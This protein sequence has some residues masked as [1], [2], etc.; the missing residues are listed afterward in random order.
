[1][2]NLYTSRRRKNPARFIIL[3]LLL[4]AVIF[5]F[6]NKFIK[7]VSQNS[8]SL[9]N[10]AISSENLKPESLQKSAPNTL[11]AAVENALSGTQGTY[12]VFIKN[13]KTNETYQINGHKVF[14]AGSLYKLWIMGEAMNQIESGDLDENEQLSEDIGV[15]NQKFRISDDLAELTDGTIDLT[16]ASAL[17]QMITISH[18][19]AALLLT[20]KLKLS[21]VAGYLKKNDLNESIV[22]TNGESPTT[23][24]ADIGLF[25]EK[26]YKVQLANPEYT[27]KMIDLLKKQTINDK[28]PIG[29]PEGISIAHKTGEIEYFT[30]DAGIV[31]SNSGDYIIAVL[32]QSDYPPGAEERISMISKAVYDYFEK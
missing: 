2:R 13:L 1:M 30:H 23:T 27:Q 29:L 32:S 17:N 28:L 9:N 4:S 3:I 5:L 19:Y 20:E 22:G 15:L 18:N 21:S 25:F 10:P 12:G 16:V 31:F 6:Y 14:E 7:S 8:K 24:P 26:L 11:G